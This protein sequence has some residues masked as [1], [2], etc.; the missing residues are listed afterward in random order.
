[1][2]RKSSPAAPQARAKGFANAWHPK[3]VRNEAVSTAPTSLQSSF[4]SLGSSRRP[5][6][7]QGCCPQASQAPGNSVRHSTSLPTRTH[8]SQGRASQVAGS[9]RGNWPSDARET[10][11]S[12]TDASTASSS[13]TSAASI[14]HQQP[15]EVTRAKFSSITSW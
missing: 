7:S 4:S 3:L 13:S 8:F 10:G 1:M 2:A 9:G 14:P 5:A 11:T 12:R 6:V 15:S